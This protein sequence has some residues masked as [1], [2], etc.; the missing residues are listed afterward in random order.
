MIKVAL[1]EDNRHLRES[2]QLVIND[3]DSMCCVGA[4]PDCSNL[5]KDILKSNPDVILMDIEMPGINGIEASKIISSQFPHIK[6]LIQT[7]FEDADRIFQAIKAG[8]AGYMLKSSNS[9]TII[10][11]IKDIMDGGAPMSP[12]V[13]RKVLTMI[14][15]PCSGSTTASNFSLTE[16]EKEIL[17][18]LVEG[19]SYKIVAD[20]LYIS[21]FTVQTHI[22]HIYEK[23]HVNSKTE[24][25]TKALKE[26]LV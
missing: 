2:I 17:Q 18:L 6:I 25:V 8:A 4:Y 5:M 14:K 16:R 10:S 12:L 3:G 7:V 22:K 26:N 15:S 23:L 20:R 1:F 13:A 9:D 19:E 24:A 11:F 21:F